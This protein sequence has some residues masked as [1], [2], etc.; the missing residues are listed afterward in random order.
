VTVCR[1]V[2]DVTAVERVFDYLVPAELT[3]RVRVGTIVRVPLQGRKVRGWVI[4]TDATPEGDARLLPIAAIVSAGPPADVVALSAWIARRWCGPRVAVLRSASPPNNVR[5]ATPN[6]LASEATPYG[7]SATPVRSGGR[8]VRRVPPLQDRR[9]LVEQL[10]A[11]AGSTVICVADGS[12]VAS[13]AR[14]LSGRGHPVALLHSDESPAARTDAWRRAAAGNCVVVGGRVAALAPVPDL[15][16]AVVVDDADEALQEERVPTWHARDVLLERAARAGAVATVVSPAPTVEAEFAVQ[17]EPTV[18]PPD[19][20]VAGWPRVIIVDR[21]EQPPGARLLTEPLAAALRATDEVAVCVLNRRGRFRLLVCDAC[22]ELLRWDKHEDRPVVCPA[23]GEARLRVIR[24]GVTRVGEELAA[25][26]PG[27]HVVDLDA[28]TGAVPPTANVVVGT[29]AA[30]HRA[31]LRRRRP[32]LVAYLDLDQE[33]LAPRYRAATQALWLLVRGAQLL[34][35]RS[36]SETRLLVQTRLPD[37]EVVRAVAEGRPQI[38][39]EGEIARRRALGYPP[40]GAL[41]ELTGDDTALARAVEQLR[42]KAEPGVQALGPSEG[43]VLVQA[44]DPDTLARVLPPA[45]ASAR[46][47]GRI[48]TV[49][50]PPRV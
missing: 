37:H 12:R 50:D 26:L 8:E 38:V 43:R 3:A 32:A 20:E 47:A 14:T 15:A 46:A 4:E 2:P 23:C 21:R 28:D 25:L 7:S 36:R 30:L 40:F 5:V 11:R 41:A 42:A 35:A 33:L 45:L 10:V 49:V 18:P 19:V 9:D 31:D 24:A 22:H 17:F 44:P 27:K 48:R 29:E 1:V 6:E 16:A 13:L 39:T 34:A